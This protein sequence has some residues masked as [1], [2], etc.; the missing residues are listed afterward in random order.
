MSLWKD[1]KSPSTTSRCVYFVIS[2]LTCGE[3]LMVPCIL[4]YTEAWPE[5]H[6]FVAP[7][8]RSSCI[9]ENRLHHSHGWSNE[10][11]PG[12][13]WQLKHGYHSAEILYPGTGRKAHLHSH[14]RMYLWTWIFDLSTAFSLIFVLTAWARDQ[15]HFYSP[16]RSRK[17][18]QWHQDGC[19]KGWFAEDSG[20]RKSP[21]I[22]L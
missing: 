5:S 2:N 17:Y 22:L 18:H 7:V 8:S 16:E 4:E 9:R 14:P 13:C 21:Q 10:N 11:S 15:W 3:P 6:F 1:L 20:A 12:C 19:Q